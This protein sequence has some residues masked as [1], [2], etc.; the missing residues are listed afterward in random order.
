MS[1]LR[2]IQ[3]GATDHSVPLADLLR[4]CKILAKRLQHTPL[5]DWANHELNGYPDAENL[6]PYRAKR[7][8]YVKGTFRNSVQ[9]IKN[10]LIPSMLVDQEHLDALFTVAHPSGVAHYESLLRSDQ[11]EFGSPWPAY[12]VAMYQTR[13]MSG[14]Y[15]T[16]ARRVISRAEIEAMLDQIRTRILS[17]VLEIEEENAAAGEAEPGGE[18]PV[19]PEKVEQS[20]VTHIYGGT[21]IVATGSQ[22]VIKDVSIMQGD[23]SSLREALEGIGVPE[24]DIAALEE[25]IEQD[26]DAEKPGPATKAWLGDVM[27]R[28]QSGSLKVATSGAGSLIANLVLTYL[29]ITQAP[30]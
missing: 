25:A 1:L 11:Q 27:T 24:G 29:G 26:A 5:S 10:K 2:E 16:E 8:A 3:D 6:P 22:N 30:G 13:M 15:L 28:I 20:F 12:V 18:P 21:N 14:M 4:K 19:A 7:S 23:W 9:E 17:F